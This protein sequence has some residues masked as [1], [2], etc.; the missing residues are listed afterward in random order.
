MIII[1]ELSL[2]FRISRILFRDKLLYLFNLSIISDI[3]FSHYFVNNG[4]EDGL[5]DGKNEIA[6]KSGKASVEEAFGYAY[7]IIKSVKPQTPFLNDSDKLFDF[8]P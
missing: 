2:Y 4:M 8:L 1:K 5:A 6:Q 7:P 3:L